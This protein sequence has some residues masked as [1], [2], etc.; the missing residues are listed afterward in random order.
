M[1]TKFKVLFIPAAL[2]ATCLLTACSR[3]PMPPTSAN[4]DSL[5]TI[6]QAAGREMTAKEIQEGRESDEAKK[7][8]ADKLFVAPFAAAGFDL[9]ATLADYAIRLRD[10]NLTQDEAQVVMGIMTIYK[11]VVVDLARWGFI[12]SET[13]DLV[14][15]AA[16]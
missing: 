2:V 16:K 11:S 1:L 5:T 4:A 15:G 3:G 9:D 12:R 6:I 10:G 7:R 14:V 8:N 13:R